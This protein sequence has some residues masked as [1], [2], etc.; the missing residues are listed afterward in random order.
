M[1]TPTR[2]TLLLRK[3][4]QY[5]Y[6]N[7]PVPP[8]DESLAAVHAEIER[9]ERAR[10]AARARGGPLLDFLNRIL[11]WGD[12]P[13]LPIRPGPTD[14][15]VLA[16]LART[17]TADTSFSAYEIARVVAGERRADVLAHGTL[18]G[19]LRKMT[20]RGWVDCSAGPEPAPGAKPGTTV[21]R[22]R[23]SEVGLRKLA[24]TGSTTRRS[25]LD[26]PGIAQPS[27]TN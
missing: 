2:T 5:L 26:A 24:D 21:R 20:D 17:G 19:S 11:P 8:V 22:Y 27:T 12:H 1:T 18:Y 6:D 13:Q 9:V 7:A 25:A 23:I 15:K 3:T 10:A 4:L 16:A 14:L